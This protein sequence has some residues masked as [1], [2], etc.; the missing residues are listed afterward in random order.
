MKGMKLLSVTGN[1]KKVNIITSRLIAVVLLCVLCA[2]TV[3]ACGST[4]VQGYGLEDA[5]RDGIISSHITEI[6]AGED[7]SG[8]NIVSPTIQQLTSGGRVQ[9]PLVFPV[10]RILSFDRREGEVT[11]F[12]E[13]NQIVEKDDVLALLTFDVDKSHDINYE[14]AVLYL[15]R[16]EQEIAAEITKRQTEIR[17]ARRPL[18]S[19]S[20]TIR[21]QIL[22]NVRLLEIDLERYIINS[23]VTRREQEEE[24]AALKKL[25]G[26]E[27]IK[28]PFDGMVTNIFTGNKIPVGTRHERNVHI[29]TIMDINTLFFQSIVNTSRDRPY[30]FMGHGDIKTMSGYI[31]NES[32]SNIRSDREPDFTFDARVASDHWATGPWDVTTF[33]LA[34]VDV[35]GLMETLK[36]LREDDP[37]ITLK[38]ALIYMPVEYIVSPRGMTLPVEATRRESARDTR[39]HVLVYDDGYMEK[40]YIDVGQV[41]GGYI[42]VTYG[43]EEDEKVVLAR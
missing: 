37:V 30:S 22:L 11:V 41:A 10:E 4:I 27:E 35:D 25:T 20:G 18:S 6:D 16:L 1:G 2:T 13:E 14:A 36:A 32:D 15:E 24:V 29:V 19:A 7:F 40:R 31:T 21:N 8:F 33:W 3:S 5:I 28:A 42:Y 17:R 26:I 43:I 9:T 23:D 39:I 38:E 34:P 12:V